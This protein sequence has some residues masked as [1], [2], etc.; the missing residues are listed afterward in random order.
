MADNK[1][2]SK[3][4]LE[5]ALTENNKKVKEYVDTGNQELTSRVD[6]IKKYQKYLNT[7]L[8]YFRAE[9]DNVIL[10][11]PVTGSG[12]LETPIYMRH[13]KSLNT[14]MEY[15]TNNGYLTLKAG[16]RYYYSLDV[17]AYL[18]SA[19]GTQIGYTLL[20]QDGTHL[21]A[22][23]GFKRWLGTQKLD[24]YGVTGIVEPE[25]DV[26]VIPAIT[27]ITGSTVERYWFNLVVHEI[28]QQT[29]IDPLEHANEKYGIEDTPVGHIISHM[30]KVAPKHYLICDGAEYNIADYPYLAEY[31]IEQYGKVNC[32]GGNGTTTFA[33][34]K[35]L[36]STISS[37]IDDNNATITFVNDPSKDV[38]SFLK[39]ELNEEIYVIADMPHT[40]EIEFTKPQL[41]TKYSL[42]RRNCDENDNK[43]MP[44]NFEIHAYDESLQQ[45][46]VL[47]SQTNQ[48]Y[49]VNTPNEYPIQNTSYYSKYRLYVTD[50]V[51]TTDLTNYFQIGYMAFYTNV[52]I[53]CI[54]YEPT[55]FM[56]NFYTN[57]IP[58]GSFINYIGEEN[59]K[60]YLP[61]DGSVYNISDYPNLAEYIKTTYGRFNSFGGDGVTTFATPIIKGAEYTVNIFATEYYDVLPVMT[62]NSSPS[63]YVVS[64]SSNVSGRSPYLVFNKTN[65]DGNDSWESYNG[66]ANPWVQIYHP[67]GINISRFDITNRNMTEKESQYPKIISLVGSDDNSTWIPLLEQIT[68]NWTTHNETLTFELDKEYKF[69]Y[70]KLYAYSQTNYTDIGK[71]E[72]YSKHT[73]KTYNHKYYI[74]AD[75]TFSTNGSI[76]ISGES[77]TDEEV[78]TAID[79]IFGGKA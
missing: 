6:E 55:Y 44:K 42:T 19:V 57:N 22:T 73:A 41:I 27:Y 8:D 75:P 39:P 77:Y 28:G 74:K 4:N 53:S 12:V 58:V 50:N 34:P 71:F 7:E 60:Y 14:N 9:A 10:E 67:D 36:L 49:Q 76:D 33:V 21:H 23:T 25:T 1:T 65:K 52:T 63:P 29:I 48:T 78:D 43:I 46:I 20:K 72:I 26:Q 79:D 32:F 69:K 54:K 35:I 70:I 15:N 18:T 51:S 13:N 66:D 61:C 47:D 59:S 37:I 38:S 62:G 5:L 31:F 30:G 40:Y 3:V 45:W 16:K 56:Q 64:A 2:L 11:T 17:Q 68:P 24:D